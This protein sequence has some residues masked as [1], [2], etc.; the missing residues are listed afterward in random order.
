MHRTRS[1]LFPPRD[2]S[3]SKTSASHRDY[4]RNATKHCENVTKTLQRMRRQKSRTCNGM[5]QV[6][7][8]MV[9]GSLICSAKYEVD[10]VARRKGKRVLTGFS[11][12]TCEYYELHLTLNRWLTKSFQQW[13]DPTRTDFTNIAGCTHT[14]KKSGAR[15]ANQLGTKSQCSSSASFSI[16]GPND[17]CE[18]QL[19]Y[20]TTSTKDGFH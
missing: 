12:Q 5:R 4:G 15:T 1:P 13:Q 6:N 3:R 7:E 14:T 19:R 9:N 10:P 17:I 18:Q 16:A 20:R 2:Q 8:E 11:T